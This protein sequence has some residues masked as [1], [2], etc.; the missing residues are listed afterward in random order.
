VERDYSRTLYRAHIEP[1]GTVWRGGPQV[2]IDHDELR[3]KRDTTAVIAYVAHRLRQAL[4]EHKLDEE[5][6]ARGGDR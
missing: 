4:A 6:A 5:E 1:E 3:R 2:R